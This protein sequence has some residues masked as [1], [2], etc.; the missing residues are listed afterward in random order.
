MPRPFIAQLIM[1]V[2]LS[3]FALCVYHALTCFDTEKK[4]YLWLQGLWVFV[5]VCAFPKTVHE[6]IHL[7][8]W[9]TDD[10]SLYGEIRNTKIPFITL[11][12]VFNYV[13]EPRFLTLETTAA[14][15]SR[16][17]GATWSNQLKTT[18]VFTLAVW[19]IIIPT[20][21]PQRLD[22]D[23]AFSKQLVSFNHTLEGL[24]F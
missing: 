8:I 21:A 15:P 17:R 6:I 4:L 10:R 24:T 23:T 5:A 12:Y 3:S 11:K 2:K 22:L 19:P 16:Q 7:L 1:L 18:S 14:T 13:T 9:F 20:V